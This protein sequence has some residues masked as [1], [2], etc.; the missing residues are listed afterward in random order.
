MWWKDLNYKR[1]NGNVKWG[2]TLRA[3]LT[4]GP[5]A[6]SIDW[7]S[8]AGILDSGCGIEIH[9][10]SQKISLRAIVSGST[11]RYGLFVNQDESGAGGPEH[12]WD[13]TLFDENEIGI[14]LRGDRLIT[15]INGDSWEK[16]LRFSA[17]YSMA[18]REPGS[19]LLIWGNMFDEVDAFPT[20]GQLEIDIPAYGDLDL[21]IDTP[22][23]LRALSTKMLFNGL[24]GDPV[25][26]NPGGGFIIG[27]TSATS[28][29]RVFALN[30]AASAWDFV[31]IT[32][33][34]KVSLPMGPNF[35]Y[36][37][38]LAALSMSFGENWGSLGFYSFGNP[39]KW[40]YFVGGFDSQELV[41]AWNGF[42]SP[43]AYP[44]TLGFS[45]FYEINITQF[46]TYIIR[47]YRDGQFELY[48]DGS[49]EPLIM[50]KINRLR[51]SKSTDPL[52]IG[53]HDPTEVA[54]L[55]WS[56]AGVKADIFPSGTFQFV[57]EY[58]SIQTFTHMPFIV[59]GDEVGA[60]LPDSSPTAN[61]NWTASSPNV[62]AQNFGDFD[63]TAD[64]GWM[65]R[66]EPGNDALF[67][68]PAEIDNLNTPFVEILE[69]ALKLEDTVGKTLLFGVKG[70]TQSFGATF[71]LSGLIEKIA[72]NT[73][74]F[75]SPTGRV[76][77]PCYLA[78]EQTHK[79]AFVAKPY[80]N[81]CLYIDE[82]SAP[83]IV[84][85]M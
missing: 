17:S 50:T 57:F 69:G 3:K 12:V 33:R 53:A 13:V 19:N 80:G 14:S 11:E 31:E 60:Y 70:S 65:I 48:V 39:S 67:T 35:G 36:P 47:Y 54:G 6:R 62:P 30:P 83:V 24:A 7:R 51:S 20:F 21:R 37:V 64:L 15:T 16:E 75:T 43:A 72:L 27:A 63:G 81:L 29:S 1:L 46:H 84:G 18:G 55:L 58:F 2:F 45:G 5:D 41:N 52:I 40:K 28:G 56:V 82:S 22:D 9:N 74:L 76:G 68:R 10:G 26:V 49:P 79:L 38:P 59:S 61:G 85:R 32:F 78:D 77:V 34:A 4:L 42:P 44:D 23:E 73:A 25:V 66:I 8:H 71:E